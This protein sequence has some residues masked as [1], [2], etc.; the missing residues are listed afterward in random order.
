MVSEDLAIITERPTV[1]KF[2]DQNRLHNEFGPAIQYADGFEIFSWH[3]TTIPDEWIIDG[4]DVKTA[5]TWENIEQRRCA[6]E[7]P[8]WAK[9][10]NEL[11]GVVIDEDED[12]YMGSLIEVDIPDI[13]KE[14]FVKV[15]C[16]T[17]REFAIP[18][19]STMQTAAILSPSNR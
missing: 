2:D 18:V 17:S 3:G 1:I 9:V 7:I 13:G 5:I 6:C 15:L 11:G 12:P 16:G 8:G 10:I 4:V 19:P 14:R